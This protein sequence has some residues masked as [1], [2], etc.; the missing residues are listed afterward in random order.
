MSKEQ[1]CQVF[2]LLLVKCS[3]NRSLQQAQPTALL[4]PSHC[5]MDRV[6]SSKCYHVSAYSLALVAREVLQVLHHQ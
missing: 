5:N 2:L 6:L 3:A 1:H 4:S